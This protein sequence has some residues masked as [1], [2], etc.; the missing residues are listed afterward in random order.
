MK[1]GNNNMEIEQELQKILAK[2]EQDE[3]LGRIAPVE[4]NFE[5]LRV[6]MEETA[7]EKG[8]YQDWCIHTI[9]SIINDKPKYRGVYNDQGYIYV[10][11]AIIDHY[12]S[13]YYC[14]EKF[15]KNPEKQHINLWWDHL[16]RN[17]MDKVFKCL[18]MSRD[19]KKKVLDSVEKK[20]NPKQLKDE[21]HF[22]HITPKGYVYN[23]I[24]QH[25]RITEEKVRECFKYS[26][27][28][29]LTQ[30]EA[31]KLD[32]AKQS[33]KQEHFNKFCEICDEIS[34]E[35]SQDFEEE[36]REAR[37]L[38]SKSPKQNGSG[39]F[40]IVYLKS[41]GVEF[42]DYNGNRKT[43]MEIYEYLIDTRMEIQ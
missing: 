8:T 26:K 34:Y 7:L 35:N 16:N 1:M 41:E 42:V 11:K 14:P 6:E 2:S 33:F 5:K 18:L 15:C 17:N 39:L 32:G 23:K 9:C 27:L 30:K 28:I 22:E 24:T 20:S 3:E 29:L 4:E 38:I 13:M 36:K 37:S 10:I 19:A 31:K 43:N 25:V 40:R 12:S 21:L